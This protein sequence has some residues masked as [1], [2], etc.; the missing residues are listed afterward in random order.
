MK[1][2]LF[3]FPELFP[4]KHDTARQKS[5]LVKEQVTANSFIC[6]FHY[7]SLLP[8]LPSLDSSTSSGLKLNYVVGLIIRR[9]ETSSCK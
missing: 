3:L 4:H 7:I 2:D 9:N 8:E 6:L 1:V 5:F